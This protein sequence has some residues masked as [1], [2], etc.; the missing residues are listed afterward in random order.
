MNPNQKVL[1]VSVTENTPTDVVIDL[2]CLDE[3]SVL[4]NA[5]F[6]N[7]FKETFLQLDQHD[8]GVLD[9]SI[10]F[11][12]QTTIDVD[13]PDQGNQTNSGTS[14][15]ISSFDGSNED[16]G[17]EIV[18]SDDSS[19]VSVVCSSGNTDSVESNLNEAHSDVFLACATDNQKCMIDKTFC[20]CTR[21]KWINVLSIISGFTIGFT[22]AAFELRSYMPDM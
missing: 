21:S 11:D 2:T 1:E 6:R 13:N 20:G 12:S 4:P 15:E 14:S 10:M 5:D 18:S 17:N 9:M 8:F 7:F 3:E 22:L 16:S 19:N